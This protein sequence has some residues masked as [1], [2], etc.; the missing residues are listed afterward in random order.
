MLQS[1]TEELLIFNTVKIKIQFINTSKGIKINN[2]YVFI[3][4]K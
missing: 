1:K 2:Y 4:K 3:P